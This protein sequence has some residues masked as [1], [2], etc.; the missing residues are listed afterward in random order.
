MTDDRWWVDLAMGAAMLVAV[1][2]VLLISTAA[3]VVMWAANV[4]EG[5]S[6]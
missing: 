2:V 3:A 4:A 1:P 5:W 6:E